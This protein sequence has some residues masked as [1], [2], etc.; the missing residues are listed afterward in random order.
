MY[1]SFHTELATSFQTERATI[2]FILGYQPE[3]SYRASYDHF[4]TGRLPLFSYRAS[5]HTFH[6]RP[7]TT[8]FI[9]S[10]VPL[11]LPS[12]LRSFSYRVIYHSFRSLLAK[13][14]SYWAIYHSFHILRAT[15]VFIQGDLPRFSYRAN[16]Q[17]SYR[18]SYDRFHTWRSTSF[19][20]DR[21]ATL[22]ND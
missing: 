5:C 12:E 14:F 20:N 21:A 9:L 17:F 11:F 10:D 15:I 7:S 3:F 2:V 1:H 16:Y 4:H 13:S 8:V 6:T 22:H 18:A 19:H